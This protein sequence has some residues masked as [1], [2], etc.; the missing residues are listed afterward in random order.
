MKPNIP[1]FIFL[2]NA[3]SNTEPTDFKTLCHVNKL[4]SLKSS[5]IIWLWS[6][7]KLRMHIWM[8]NS[9]D[10]LAMLAAQPIT[11]TKEAPEYIYPCWPVPCF[12][13]S[14]CCIKT[15]Q[16]FGNII[17]HQHWGTHW[18]WWR[19]IYVKNGLVSMT[20]KFQLSKAAALCELIRPFPIKASN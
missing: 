1:T 8:N 12:S 13:T 7:D 4:N 17:T 14:C 15:E 3:L 16:V 18:V 9:A 5:L 6:I 20:T 2:T 19:L 11:K 10:R